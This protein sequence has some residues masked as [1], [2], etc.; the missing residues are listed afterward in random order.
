[1]QQTRTRPGPGT[2]TR[3]RASP[4]LCPGLLLGERGADVAM[5]G[6]LACNGGVRFVVH[7]SRESVHE[8][9]GG[10]YPWFDCFAQ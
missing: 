9:V 2:R 10:S 6:G 7:R 5:V 1:M 3:A 8:G 4:S